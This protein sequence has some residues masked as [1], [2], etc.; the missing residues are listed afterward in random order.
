VTGAAL[1]LVRHARPRIDPDIP[2]SKWELCPDGRIAAVALAGKLAVYSPACVVSSTERKAEETAHILADE[3]KVPLE[4]DAGLG[5][6]K[7]P[8]A[9]F[10]S[11][12]EFQARI[13]EI[14]ANP[15]VPAPGGESAEEACERLAAA[16][17]RH[18]A[19]PLVAVTH[20]TVLSLYIAY[21]LGLDAHDLWRALHTPDAFVFDAEN[22]L[23]ARVG[24]TTPTPFPPRPAGRSPSPGR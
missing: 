6:H 13:A 16:L 2:P 24:A 1:I 9:S 23:I 12:Q 17:A 14:F 7:R 21:L 22:K 10:G 8:S 3:L 19:R 4:F 11:E 5:E 18:A 15:R 20:G